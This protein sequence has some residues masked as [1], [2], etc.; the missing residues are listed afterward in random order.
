MTNADGKD[1]NLIGYVAALQNDGTTQKKI[2]RM[3]EIDVTHR[4]SSPLVVTEEGTTIL[5][6][7]N[8]G[9]TGK[10]D[11]FRSHY[12]VKIVAE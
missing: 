6:V 12:S 1:T 5:R 2:A 7:A 8:V 9:G 10:P 11:Q 4:M 3:N